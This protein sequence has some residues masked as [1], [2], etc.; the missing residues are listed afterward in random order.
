MNLLA[1]HSAAIFMGKITS[2][3]NMGA[4]SEGLQRPIKKK[5]SKRFRQ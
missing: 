2:A 1:E 5:L 4:A 3:L